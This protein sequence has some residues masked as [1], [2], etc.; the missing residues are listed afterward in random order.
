MIMKLVV[1]L[2]GKKIVEG[3]LEKWGISKTKIVAVVGVILYAVEA[4]SPAFGWDIK[5]SDD[6]KQALLAAGLWTLKDGM[7]KPENA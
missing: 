1:K 7:D 3:A 4:L 5:I 2:F 6:L